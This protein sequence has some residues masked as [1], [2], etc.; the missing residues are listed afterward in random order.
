MIQFKNLVQVLRRASVL[1]GIDLEIGIGERVALIEL[2]GA[3]KTTLIRCLFGEYDHQGE[4]RIDGLDPRSNR[5]AVLGRIGRAAAAAA[6]EDAGRPADRLRRRCARPTR[7]ASTPSASA[8]GSTSTA[9]SA[10]R[11]VACPA[12]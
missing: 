5:T 4:V 3:G 2:N 11:F 7:R 1:N 12:A 6:A 10:A 9:S 8:S